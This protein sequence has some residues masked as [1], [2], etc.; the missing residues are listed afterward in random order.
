MESME[1]DGIYKSAWVSWKYMDSMGNLKGFGGVE[2]PWWA[3][4]GVEILSEDAA[5]DMQRQS[6]DRESIRYPLKA[7][8]TYI[9][10]L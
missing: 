4:W 2:R 3:V 9:E 6:S 7:C 10:H 1:I 8:R 5:V